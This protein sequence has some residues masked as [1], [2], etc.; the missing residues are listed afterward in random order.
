MEMSP[1]RR[2]QWDA[3]AVWR[4]LL[5]RHPVRDA[6]PSGSCGQ[7]DR[8]TLA[9]FCEA[10]ADYPDFLQDTLLVIAHA[11]GFGTAAEALDSAV[12]EQLGARDAGTPPMLVQGAVKG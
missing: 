9:G 12:R 3:Y 4:I 1:A 5:Q 8:E 7:I 2:P 6:D 11:E 10:I